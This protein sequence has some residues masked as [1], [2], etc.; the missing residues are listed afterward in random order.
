MGWGGFHGVSA[1]DG[2]GSW[3]SINKPNM[4]SS[5]F[6]LLLSCCISCLSPAR[7]TG[8]PA[9][10]WH[11][12][13][14]LLMLLALPPSHGLGLPQRAACELQTLAAGLGTGGLWCS[15]LQ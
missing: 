6:L 4:S 1:C 3:Q 7:I 2:E 8:S 12:Q 9:W 10:C 13:P 14:P 11:S 15:S 5:F